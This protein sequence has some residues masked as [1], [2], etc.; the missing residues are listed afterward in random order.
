MRSILCSEMLWLLNASYIVNHCLLCT[1]QL[2]YVVRSSTG[3]V[4]VAAD[5]GWFVTQLQDARDAT[6][7]LRQEQLSLVKQMEGQLRTLCKIEALLPSH[8]WSA[9]LQV[10]SRQA[11]P[12]TCMPMSCS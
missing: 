2:Q 3:A 7:V 1:G 12:R 5:A 8:G 4:G 9:S 6:E 10:S 11:L